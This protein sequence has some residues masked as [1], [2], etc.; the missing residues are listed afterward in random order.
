MSD[1]LK[2]G[3]IGANWGLISHLPAWQSLPGVQVH[4]ICTAHR[5]T[6]E[7]AA[8]DFG[9]PRAYWDYRDMMRDPEIDIVDVG[10]RPS[11]RY[12]MVMAALAAGK[13]VYNANP[14]AMDMAQAR[15]ML[16]EQQR[17]GVVGQVDAQFQWVPQ[18]ARMKELLDEGFIGDLYSVSVNCHFPLLAG[19]DCCYPFVA[20]TGVGQPYSWLADDASGASVLRN[21]GGHCL[22]GLIFLFGEIQEVSACLDTFLKEWKF[23]DGSMLVPKTADTAH[24]LMKFR[25]GGM[26]HLNVGWVVADAAG[27]SLEAYGSKGRLHLQATTGFPD[28]LTARLYGAPCAPQ[29]TGAAQAVELAIPQHLLA[30]PGVAVAPDDPRPT[31]IPML[32]MFDSMVRAIRAGGAAKPDFAQAC[33][34][35][36]VVEAAERAHAER[37]WIAI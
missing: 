31:V 1:V 32:K 33:H 15:A 3:I 21:L 29:Y 7:R 5:E 30:I 14:F 23:A 36:A 22:H 25:R 20:H 34:V 16:A 37:R 19:D 18:L 11:L 27:F 4:A 24:V 12:D 9:I 35:Q 8:R 17:R 26:G 6:A 13:H 28:T 2:V 10:T